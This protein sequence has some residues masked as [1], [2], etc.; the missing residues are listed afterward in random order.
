MPYLISYGYVCFMAFLTIKM[1]APN[2]PHPLLG[3]QI[4]KRLSKCR[5]SLKKSYIYNNVS[6]YITMYMDWKTS[7][8]FLLI[9]FH[10][11]VL[12]SLHMISA[13]FTFHYWSE[14]TNESCHDK[15]SIK[16]LWPAWIQTSLRICAVWSGSMLFAISFS[17]CYRVCKR[18]AWILIRLRGCAG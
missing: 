5:V 10:E 9:P 1:F 18:T 3:T 4:K 11:R 15:V 2:S 13:Y 8:K 16:G 6:S 12:S 17:T 14:L 7:I